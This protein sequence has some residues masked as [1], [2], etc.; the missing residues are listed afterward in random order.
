MAK[1]LKDAESWERDEWRAL[2]RYTSTAD[3]GESS[4]TEM[5]AQPAEPERY[6]PLGPEEVQSIREVREAMSL[7][8]Q[9]GSSEHQTSE[10]PDA[11]AA[12]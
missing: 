2:D 8:A 7:C 12:E 1:F 3:G 11:D 6:Q 10:C 4:P 9:C 5:R